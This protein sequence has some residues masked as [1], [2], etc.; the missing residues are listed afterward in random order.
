[1][2]TSDG[3]TFVFPPSVVAD[4][5]LVVVLVRHGRTAW[6][7]ERR[8]QGR[9]DQ[10]L[11][12]VGRA[13]VAGLSVLRGRFDAVYTSPLR[14]ARETAEVFADGPEVLE[15]MTE[16]DLGELDGTPT[17]DA[18]NTHPEFL[19][20]WGLDPTDVAAPGGGESMGAVQERAVR[21]LSALAQAHPTGRIAVACHQMVIAAVSCH[22]EG[23]PLRKWRKY[24]V[25]NAEMSAIG[26]WP[27]RFELLA[28]GLSVPT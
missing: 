12:D 15:D 13:Q 5:G 25:K 3:S 1:M 11:D 20:R 9:A 19:A 28:K 24:M 14:R 23:V 17:M 6:N 2:A 26:V 8:F 16:L 21:R 18:M 27:G 10:P 22:A 7:A 4:G